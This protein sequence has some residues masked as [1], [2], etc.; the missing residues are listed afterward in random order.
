MHILSSFLVVFMLLLSNAAH[1]IEISGSDDPVFQEAKDAWLQGDDAASLPALAEM[2]KKGN[3]AARYLLSQIER[4]THFSSETDFV[5]NL[6]RK[7]RLALFRA[8]GGLSGTAWLEL[9]EEDGEQLAAIL[10]GM[11]TTN[12]DHD[13]LVA[14]IDLGEHRLAYK[15]LTRHLG[16]GNYEL[17]ELLYEE[18]D[19]TTGE[20]HYAWYAS[21]LNQETTPERRAR[22]L[23]AFKEDLKTFGVD[24]AIFIRWAYRYLTPKNEALEQAARFGDAVLLPSR[25]YT[26]ERKWTSDERVMFYD[27]LKEK[28]PNT[29]TLTLPYIYCRQQCPEDIGRCMAAVLD[30][31]GGY[32]AIRLFQSPLENLIANGDYLTSPRALTALS[33]RLQWQTTQF[34]TNKRYKMSACLAKTLSQK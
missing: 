8:P 6:D 33:G 30:M 10:R 23:A 13:Q 16:Y 31:A 22:T 11:K 26:R 15:E 2:A 28:A 5:K 4:M 29:E 27:W 7:Q 9:L 25:M 18:N 1:A 12:Y 3:K 17:L 21:I 32:E 19:L 14:L 34:D 20:R 24:S